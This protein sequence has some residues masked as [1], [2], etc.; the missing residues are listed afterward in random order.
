VVEQAVEELVEIGMPLGQLLRPA[1]ADGAGRDL[2]GE[3]AA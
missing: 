1:V 2:R 3:V